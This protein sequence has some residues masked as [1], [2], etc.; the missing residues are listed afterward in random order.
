MRNGEH[1][2]W[3]NG[4]VSDLL[5]MGYG[6]S[7][8]LSNGVELKRRADESFK[9]AEFR[10]ENHQN[11][12]DLIDSVLALKRAM[13]ARLEHLDEIYG[14]KQYPDCKT[15]GWLGVLEGW[16]AVR[17]RMLKRM[18]G[19]R[20]A[21][22]H[23]GASPPAV[24][25]CEDYREVVWWF[26]KATAPLLEPIEDFDFQW[27]D[28]TGVIDISYNPLGVE[29]WGR[30]TAEHICDSARPGWIEVQPIPSRHAKTKGEMTPIFDADTG[31]Y[32]LCA[33]ASSWESVRPFFEVS[34][35]IIG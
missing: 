33:K 17:Q 1:P 30:F 11:K 19:L 16:G 10:L 24:D 27:G 6:G 14:F 31:L 12:Y 35:D 4:D 29:L 26:L 34:M 32:Y 15:R 25:E 9:H 20:N 22:E 21:V 3:L 2:R 28:S 13:Q 18:N 8:G 7:A 5:V 23:D